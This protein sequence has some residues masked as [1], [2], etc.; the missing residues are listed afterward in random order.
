MVTYN[1]TRRN[2]NIGTTKQGHGRDNRLVIPDVSN[3]ERGWEEELGRHQRILKHVKGRQILF[4]VDKN[5]NGCVHAC[6]IADILHVLEY[7]P[8][9]D[10]TGVNTFFLRQSTRKQRLLKPV[11]G[12]LLYHA[13]VSRFGQDSRQTGPAVILEAF[14][15]NEI[16][17]WPTSLRPQDQQELTRLSNDG[18]LIS[19]KGRH[20]IIHTTESSVRATQ[21]YRTLLHEIGHWIHYVE[22]V[23][24][25]SELGVDDQQSL[26]SVYF[27]RTVDEREAFAHSY[28]EKNRLHLEK[29]GIIPFNRIDILE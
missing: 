1:P 18:H 29:F 2:R 3:G 12:K 4:I 5:N 9:Q 24:K 20:H 27:G 23:V 13:N 25:P 14:G 8:S 15:L 7:L 26:A 16:I 10:W 22:N 11:W 17:K 21:L 19:R 6:S 28:A